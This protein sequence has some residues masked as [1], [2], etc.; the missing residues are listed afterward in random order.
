MRQRMSLFSKR[1]QSSKTG[2]KRVHESTITTD[3]SQP[4]EVARQART[5]LFTI[6][7]DHF[8]H[9]DYVCNLLLDDLV[10]DSGA[11]LDVN[12]AR[13]PDSRIFPRSVLQAV[14]II[15]SCG[16]ANFERTSWSTQCCHTFWELRDELATAADYDKFL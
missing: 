10:I 1:R 8:V 7:I 2:T 6:R 14:T 11:E 16:L 9:D 3:D 4:L 15:V 13:S 5:R 12:V